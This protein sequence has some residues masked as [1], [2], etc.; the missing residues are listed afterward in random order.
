MAS[1]ELNGAVSPANW[2]RKIAGP[3]MVLIRRISAPPCRC[4]TYRAGA[5]RAF[6][7]APDR[8]ATG[9]PSLGGKRVGE[10]APAVPSPAGRTPSG[11]Q[12][13][14]KRAGETA[15]VPSPADR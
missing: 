4:T 13:G 10:A 15:P 3:L 1:S 9:S 14:R 12:L 6:A 11:G 8:S 5:P 7:P 2:A